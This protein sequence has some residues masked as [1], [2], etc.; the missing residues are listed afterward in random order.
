MKKLML[1]MMVVLGIVASTTTVKADPLPDCVNN[2]LLQAAVNACAAQGF[3][4][5]HSEFQPI[6]YLVEPDPPY[7]A[8]YATVVLVPDC[9]PLEPCPRIAK[10]VTA[11]V[12]ALPNG[13]C[14][15]RQANT[16]TLPN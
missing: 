1:T 15:Y 9:A 16:N 4:V 2:G 12:W 13:N 6:L 7:L 3:V 14:Q 11:E 10:L 5:S 8:G